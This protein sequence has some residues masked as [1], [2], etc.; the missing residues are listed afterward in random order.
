MAVEAV[1]ACLEPGFPDRVEGVSRSTVRIVAVYVADVVNGRRGWQFYAAL[2]TVAFDLGLSVRVVRR[3]MA[4]LVEA[5][6]LE[7][8]EERSGRTTLYRWIWALPRSGQTGG[9]VE[10]DRG[11]PVWADLRTQ[12]GTQLRSIKPREMLTTVHDDDCPGGCE[13]TGWIEVGDRTV[14]RCAGRPPSAK[15]LA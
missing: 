6:V 13:G 10:A 3:V 1:K 8:V 14:D 4:H 2:T 15:L 9:A 12:E 5:S 11:A 7:L